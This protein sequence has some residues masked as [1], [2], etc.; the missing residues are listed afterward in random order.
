MDFRVVKRDGKLEDF[1]KG[2]IERVLKAAGLT[3]QEA[4]NLTRKVVDWI[5]SLD[6]RK[7]NSTQIKDKVHEELKKVNEYSAGL[8]EW[9]ERTKEKEETSK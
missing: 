6:Q 8:Y 9:Y 4:M 2:K 7:V 5:T 1:E 3:G